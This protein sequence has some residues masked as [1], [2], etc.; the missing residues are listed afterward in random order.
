MEVEWYREIGEI[1]WNKRDL[2]NH[3][4][5]TWSTSFLKLHLLRRP[6]CQFTESPIHRSS[7]QELFCK[8]SVLR[9]FAKFTGKHMCQ[10]LFFN[11][12]TGLR[13][14][15]SLEDSETLR[16]R[17]FWHRCFPV[18]FAK[19]LRTSFFYRAA[20]EAASEYIKWD[21]LKI[22]QAAEFSE[23]ELAHGGTT[24]IRAKGEKITSRRS[25]HWTLWGR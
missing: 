14:A 24:Y 25:R 9:N 16:L 4:L 8:K 7:R 23:V 20:P 2:K 21:T 5:P 17:D 15:T 6:W 3:F 22:F 12:I 13:P 18:N 11:E 10:S 1:P 19:F